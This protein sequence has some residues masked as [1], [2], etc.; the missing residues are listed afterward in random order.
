[1]GRVEFLRM[2]TEEDNATSDLINS[3][4]NELKNAAKQL[5]NDATK[6]GGLGFGTSFLKWVASF[7]AMSDFFFFS[8]A[9]R[10]IV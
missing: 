5:I 6:L 1:M 8:F 9:R 7:A 2:K 4:M 10:L 3:D